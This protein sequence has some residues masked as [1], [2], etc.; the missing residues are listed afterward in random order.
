MSEA[1][2]VL[3][4]VIPAYN[5][6]SR[7]KPSLQCVVDY[8]ELHHFCYEVI[9]VDD[10][11]DDATASIAERFTREGYPV[12]LLANASNQGKGSAVRL[13]MLAARG[14]FVLMTDADLSTPISELPRLLDP[15]RRGAPVVVGSRKMRGARILQHQPPAREWM[16]KVFSSLARTLILTDVSDFTC[17]F[18]LFRGE[19]VAPIFGRLRQPG[20]A[21]DAELLYIAHKLG[22]E[23]IEV[24]VTWLDNSDTRVRVGRAAVSSLYGLFAIRFNDLL[25]RYN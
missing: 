17:G 12:E 7:L 16:G 4:V 24:P 9:V 21:Y 18:K 8:C 1:A 6:E 22:S 25:G 15:A 13:G 5:E 20:W 23:I 11:S 19:W 3:S 10:G 14:R 2:P